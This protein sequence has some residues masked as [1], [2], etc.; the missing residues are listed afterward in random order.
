VTLL[1]SFFEIY[2]SII[3]KEKYID[4]IETNEYY[5]LN[6][7][8]V[9]RIDTIGLPIYGILLNRRNEEIEFAYLTP[10][11]ALASVDAISFKVSDIFDIVKLTH[12]KFLFSS[13]KMKSYFKKLKPV[14]NLELVIDNLKILE[15][16]KYG[17]VHRR[18]FEIE[19]QRVTN[20]LE[21]IDKNKK[22]IRVPTESKEEL[23]KL[24]SIP[25]AD[26]H[27]KTFKLDRIICSFE[28]IGLKL[29]FPDDLLD[30]SCQISIFDTVIY[31]GKAKNGLILQGIPLLPLDK[32]LKILKIEFQ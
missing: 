26:S 9:F 2:E 4:V 21:I 22:I 8:D 1:D 31:K 28:P 32:I 29:Y 17:L 11:L 6:P 10:F 24:A 13:S 19:E 7:G 27:T 30:K 14:K 25:A 23:L 12:L 3:E 5:E 18:F 15:S 20:V 16:K